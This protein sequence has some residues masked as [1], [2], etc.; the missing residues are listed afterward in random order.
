MDTEKF[1]VG[2]TLPIAAAQRY[3][4]LVKAKNSTNF[5]YKIRLNLSPE[6]PDLVDVP[7]AGK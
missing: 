5:N 2:D 1:T 7:P 3:S 6:M 4:V